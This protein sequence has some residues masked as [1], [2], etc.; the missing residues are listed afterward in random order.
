MALRT[1]HSVNKI[2][3][4]SFHRWIIEEWKRKNR[5]LITKHYWRR[6]FILYKRLW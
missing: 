3:K 1:L 6:G 4:N 2:Y 5:P